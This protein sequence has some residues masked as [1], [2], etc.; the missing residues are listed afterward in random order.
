MAN[1]NETIRDRMIADAHLLLRQVEGHVIEPVK[2]TIT[3]GAN[4]TI[5]LSSALALLP[6]SIQ[7]AMRLN[8]LQKIDKAILAVATQ[9]PLTSKR[10]ASISGYAFN[11]HFSA[12][13]RRLVLKDLLIHTA[14]G[15]RLPGSR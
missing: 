4:T 11:S 5:V 7:H 9:E 6:P 8:K 15:Y 14:D 2:I 3:S 12:S 1:G 10:L 13:L